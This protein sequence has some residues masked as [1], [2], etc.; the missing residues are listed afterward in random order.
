[1]SCREQQVGPA[2]VWPFCLQPVMTMEYGV[3]SMEYGVWSME[4]G[5]WSVEVR[6]GRNGTARPLLHLQ[7]LPNMSLWIPRI[8]AGLGRL[9]PNL[10]LQRTDC[11]QCC[12]GHQH[13]AGSQE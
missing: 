10:A 9:E 4:C 6:A 12:S 5:V 2:D 1:M 7:L 11:G 3:W 8:V 13:E